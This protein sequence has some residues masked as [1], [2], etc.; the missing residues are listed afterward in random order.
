MVLVQLYRH[1]GLTQSK[2]TIERPVH[3]YVLKRPGQ[4]HRNV[5]QEA[6][7]LA[8]LEAR[9]AS[10]RFGASNLVTSMLEP[11]VDIGYGKVVERCRTIFFHVGSVFENGW[12][13]SCKVTML[14][15]SSSVAFSWAELQCA[16]VLLRFSIFQSKRD[17]RGDEFVG[18]GW[19]TWQTRI[20]T[21]TGRQREWTNQTGE[22]VMICFSVLSPHHVYKVFAGRPPGAQILQSWETMKNHYSLMMYSPKLGYISLFCIQKSPFA[23]IFQA[24]PSKSGGK[25]WHCE[26]ARG[27]FRLRSPMQRCSTGLQ[28]AWALSP[29]IWKNRFLGRPG[30]FCHMNGG[31][32]WPTLI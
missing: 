16:C 28:Q 1:T 4:L 11:E 10:W 12:F 14:R 19:G 22:Y 3:T 24:I 7:S 20:P 23:S 13:R 9:E 17:G 21:R 32:L 18:F 15:K 5:V 30:W 25:H 29:D 26:Q 6:S 27:L 8:G 2:C 31:K